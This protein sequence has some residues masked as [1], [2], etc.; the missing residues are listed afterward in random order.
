MRGVS[1]ERS[2]ESMNKHR[3]EAGEQGEQANS[4]EALVINAT[5]I[6]RGGWAAKESILS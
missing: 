2:G 5:R 4:C 1:V 3:M 6:R